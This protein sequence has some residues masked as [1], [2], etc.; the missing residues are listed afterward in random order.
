[1]THDTKLP[2]QVPVLVVGAGLAGLG[3]ARTLVA[4]GH[5]VH[6]VEAGDG[7]GGRVR[8][9]DV[10]GFRLD[11]GF[12]VILTA[13]PEIREQVDLQRLRL[14]AFRPG[15]LIRRN[16]RMELLADPWRNPAGAFASLFAGVGSL[17]DKLK[18]AKLRADLKS[19]PLDGLLEGPDRSTLEE[20]RAHGFSESFIDGFFRPFL[21]GVFLERD[22]DTSARLFRY[23]FRLFAEGDTSVP[24]KGMQALPDQLAEPL[25]GRIT[26][27][28]PVQVVETGRAVLRDGSEVRADWIV[29]ATDGPSSVGLVGGGAP[30]YK[31][32]VTTYFDAPEAPASEAM[33]ILDGDGVGP[34]NH[35]AVMSNVAPS[36]APRGRHLI[37]ASGVGSAASDPEGFPAA[38]RAQLE[39]WFGPAVREWREIRSYTIRAALPHQP[40]G[41]LDPDRGPDLSRDRI[42]VCGDHRL[43]GSLQGALESGRRTAERI[44]GGAGAG[45]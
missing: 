37:S 27:R 21:G 16:G 2:S 13:Y 20:L 43:H 29:V 35:L 10:E 8:T 17:G 11:R 30:S 26:L 23:L 14:H 4:A 33:L 19:E 24:E 18:T 1:M 41:A 6:V 45:P 44:L 36:Y 28:S 39:G 3:C 32:T 5:E 34:V 12:Q 40:A 22:L 9:D 38:A 25:E 7:V 31:T 42:A 15:S